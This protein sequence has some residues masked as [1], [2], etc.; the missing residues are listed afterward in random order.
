MEFTNLPFSEEDGESLIDIS[1]YYIKIFFAAYPESE[2]PFDALKGIDRS[3]LHYF[4]KEGKKKRIINHLKKK[5]MQNT[6]SKNS[7]TGDMK[8]RLNERLLPGYR[9]MTQ[10]HL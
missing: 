4:E 8:G 7:D 2:A 9:W 6:S 1:N 5:A 10:G 3:L